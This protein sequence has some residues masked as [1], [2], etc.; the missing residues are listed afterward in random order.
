MTTRLRLATI[1]LDTGAAITSPWRDKVLLS[2]TCA[3][4]RAAAAVT[5]VAIAAHAIAPA[6]CSSSANANC[7]KVIGVESS[8]CE[9]G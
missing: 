2:H 8:K 3:G 6:C 4:A 9:C 5:V 1:F 7:G